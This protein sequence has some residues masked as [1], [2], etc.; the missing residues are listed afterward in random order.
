MKF[1]LLLNCR[2]VRTLNPSPIL[3]E[4]A[5][6]I[7]LLYSYTFRYLLLPSGLHICATSW[8]LHFCSLLSF[9]ALL[10]MCSKH[11][12]QLVSLCDP[13]RVLLVA[14]RSEKTVNMDQRFPLILETLN[15]IVYKITYQ[16]WEEGSCQF[17][18]VHFSN[19]LFHIQ[20][21]LNFFVQ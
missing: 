2:N 15:W 11:V 6:D 3:C 5:P 21:L 20:K 14:H 19:I 4:E 13:V 7:I 12:R 17:M 1:R 16:T 8:A 10:S 9:Q 18:Y